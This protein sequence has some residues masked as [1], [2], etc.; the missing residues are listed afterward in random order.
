MKD[1]I[2][3]QGIIFQKAA[4]IENAKEILKLK[5]VYADQHQKIKHG[6]YAIWGMVGLFFIGMIAEGFQFDFDPFVMGVNL[7]IVLIMAGTGLL[8]FKNPFLGFL[9]GVIFIILVQG[10]IFIGA[11]FSEG[12]NGIL[13]RMIILY[14]MVLGMGAAKK[15]SNA[16]HGLRTHGINIDS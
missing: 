1:E 7:T 3:D 9:L 12:L 15:Y 14:Y 4:S 8:S 13:P 10:L 5:S 6:R 16:L 2:L 11:D